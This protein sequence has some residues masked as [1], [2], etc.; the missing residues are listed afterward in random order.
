MLCGYNPQ[1]YHKSEAYREEKKVFVI[2]MTNQILN[3]IET[4]ETSRQI[5]HGK[6]VLFNY[7]MIFLSSLSNLCFVVGRIF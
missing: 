4:K 5:Y 1:I 7:H 6:T 2:R 3:M